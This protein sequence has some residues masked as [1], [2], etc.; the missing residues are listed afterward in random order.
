MLVTYLV[1]GVYLTGLA[2]ISAALIYIGIEIYSDLR[3]G[4]K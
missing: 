1:A 4:I 3:D 2:V